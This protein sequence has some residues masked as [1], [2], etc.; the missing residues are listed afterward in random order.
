ML[1]I[2]LEFLR[3]FFL[4]QLKYVQNKKYLY[5]HDPPVALRIIEPTFNCRQ[6]VHT[7]GS[8][9]ETVGSSHCHVHKWFHRSLTD[10]L[11]I[12]P[13]VAYYGL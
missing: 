12:P 10:N 8:Q 7:A 6:V 3:Y 2:F 1:N 4:V 13:L 5:L 11:T 9:P